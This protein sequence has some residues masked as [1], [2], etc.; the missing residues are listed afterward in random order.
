M[1]MHRRD[2]LRT[3]SLA[4]LGGL[5][6]R[7]MSSA[8]LMPLLN[9]LA[10]DR[11]LVIV[12]LYGGNDGLNTVIPLDQYSAL[13][14][15][16]SNILIPEGQVLPLSGTGGATGLH[17]KLDGFQH[18]WND[19]KLAIVQ[20]VGYPD[21]N[22]SHFRST[23]IWETAAN[24]D[25]VLSSGWLGRYLSAEY[26]NYPVDYPNATMPDP[27]AIRVGAPLSAGLQFQGVSMGTSI[28]N[29]LDPFDLSEN[30]YVDPLPADCRGDK[31]G[32]MRTIQRQTDL[33]GDVVN[34]A[35]SPGC[36]LSTLYPS[37]SHPG[38]GLAYSLQIVARLICGGLKTR[39]Y[40]VSTSGF[41]THA[42]QVDQSD[43]SAG[44]HARLLEGM[45]DAIRAFQD[46]LQLLGVD[47]RVIG[48]TFSEFGRRIA[49][50]ASGGTDHG[51]SGPMFLF[52]SNVIPGMLGTNPVIDPA[53]TAATNLPMQ[54]DFRSV[55][56]SI[57][58][59][60]FCMPPG[61]VASVL[62]GDHQPLALV[63]PA[64]CMSTSVHEANQV[65]GRSVLEV[66]P[67][68][69]VQRTNIKFTST[70]GPILLQV[71]DDH[72]R[73]IVTLRNEVVPVGD[74]IVECDLEGQATGSYYCR[75]QN[76]GHQQVRS[77]LKVR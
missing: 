13:S 17:P 1:S 37:G 57:L 54:Y 71:F 60:W 70:G 20:G 21:P 50:N 12:Q 73:L 39:I 28:Y 44:K 29:T 30:A 75:L 15:L 18:L 53:S 41:D 46:D 16:R 42:L 55:Y 40:W 2:F 10:D 59:D 45:G 64:G 33:F 52:G 74:H 32:L 49:S 7:G 65:A 34:A 35:S 47:D 76:G 68:P 77:M 3:V 23:D 11:V 62:P 19:G 61:D 4:S 31:L 6:L 51:T 43:H 24:S 69:F 58:R 25:E 9:G 26:P 48:M 22:F 5:T 66:Y 56:A 8:R 63:D 72:G 67:N 38:A 14:G 36:N 27:L